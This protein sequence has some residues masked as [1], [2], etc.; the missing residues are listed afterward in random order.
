LLP[1]AAAS[2]LA[3]R[4]PERFNPQISS[5]GGNT[6]IRR[7]ARFDIASIFINVDPVKVWI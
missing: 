1:R 5:N 2:A 3:E 4:H 6:A 7:N